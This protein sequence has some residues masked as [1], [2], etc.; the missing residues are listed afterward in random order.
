MF[1]LIVQWPDSSNFTRPFRDWVDHCLLTVHT[2]SQV[3]KEVKSLKPKQAREF[4]SL[5]PVLIRRLKTE[6]TQRRK[7]YL[8]VCAQHDVGVTFYHNEDA[9]STS[10]SECDEAVQQYNS[11]KSIFD[12]IC[13]VIDVPTLLPPMLSHRYFMRYRQHI[14]QRVKYLTAENLMAN[15]Q[16]DADGTAVIISI[17]A[18]LRAIRDASDDITVNER[19]ATEKRWQKKLRLFLSYENSRRKY[20]KKVVRMQ[21]EAE[22]NEFVRTCNETE[23]GI[24]DLQD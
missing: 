16:N 19:R 1:T 22:W 7:D 3:I 21:A 13:A 8:N 18:K 10:S 4:A 15:N 11:V 20:A 14:S 24:D 12:A 17:Q 9:V 5:L 6:T 2:A 23:Q